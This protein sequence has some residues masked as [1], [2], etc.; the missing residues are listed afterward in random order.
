MDLRPAG[1]TSTRYRKR[2][3]RVTFLGV[4][5]LLVD[6]GDT[7]LLT[8]GFFSRP[9]LWRVALRPLHPDPARIAAGLRRAAIGD[10][11]AVLVTHSHYDHAL[12]APAVAAS[13]GALLV[14]SPSTRQIAAGYG[15]PLDR[16]A[17][18]PVAEPLRLGRFTVTA[19]ESTHA[20]PERYPGSIDAPLHAPARAK[21]FRTGQCWSFHIGHPDGSLLVQASANFRPSALAGLRADTVYLGIGQLGLRDDAFRDRYWS[22]VVGAVQSRRVVPI[23]WDDF[24]RPFEPG[25]RPIPWPFDRHRR[26]MNWLARTCAARHVELVMP[27]PWQPMNPFPG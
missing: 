6:D 21:R 2:V 7:S 20:H 11:S 10:L 18:A 16:F 25:V 9:G 1:T 4:A 23:H 14:G 3:I 5:T 26:T 13:T 27:E 15:F 19:V 17:P 8:D 22:E 12:D 24:F